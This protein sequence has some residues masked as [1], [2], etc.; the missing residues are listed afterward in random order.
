MVFGDGDYTALRGLFG[1]DVDGL[2]GVVRLD[3]HLP[4]DWDNASVE[5]IHVGASVCSLEYR[6]QGQSLVVK[7]STVSGPVIRLASAVKGSRVAS[8]GASIV[9]ALPAVEVAVP[10][11]LPLPGARTAQ[12]KVLG[13]TFGGALVEAGAGGRGWSRRDAEGSTEW[14][15]GEPSRGGRNDFERDRWP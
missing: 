10:H 3:P 6:R 5:R 15:Q 12:M 9:F 2:S 13:E 4:A 7:V 1:I 11:G 14:R 8:D